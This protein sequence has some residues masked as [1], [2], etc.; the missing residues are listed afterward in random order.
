MTRRQYRITRCS[1][2]Q[3]DFQSSHHDFQWNVTNTTS[4]HTH[5]YTHTIRSRW[6][7]HKIASWLHGHQKFKRG[8]HQSP[9]NCRSLIIHQ[10]IL[11]VGSAKTCSEDCT[12]FFELEKRWAISP[13]PTEIVYWTRVTLYNLY[14]FIPSPRFSV[15]GI[16]FYPCPSVPEYVSV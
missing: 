5:T 3:K 4:P 8:R 14:Y 2:L 16:F 9:K 12:L 1:I 11:V 13:S 10:F 15:V 7:Q 6:L